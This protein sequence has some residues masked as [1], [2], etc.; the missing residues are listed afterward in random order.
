MRGLFSEGVFDV[1]LEHQV[2]FDAL[3]GVSAGACFGCNYKSRQIGRAIRYNKRFA[4]DPRYMGIGS[5]LRTGNFI[6]AHYAYLVVPRVFDY[7]DT[8]AFAANPMAFYM[9]CT[10]VHT[11]KPVYGRYDQVDSNMLDWMRASASMPLLSTPVAINGLH[12]L[13]G[14]ISDSIPLAFSQQQ[15]YERNVVILTQPL[16]FVKK[17]TKLMPLF[18]LFMRKYPAIIQAMERRHDMY[19]AQLDYLK[20]EEQ[21]GNTLLIY[22]SSELPISRLEKRPERL[23]RIYD[24]GREIGQQR[25]GEVID[26]LQ[27]S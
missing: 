8:Q 10:D 2:Q 5:W 14:G 18:H 7:F 4:S 11:G 19:N 24:K 26:F 27:H 20:Q 13:D 25:I 1:M 22:P 23:Q 15:G 16:G 17:R 12:L 3:I 9:V 21:K 6:N